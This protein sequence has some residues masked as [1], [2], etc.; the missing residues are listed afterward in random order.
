MDT[1]NNVEQ[2]LDTIMDAKTE[3]SHL[4]EKSSLQEE[5]AFN[6]V[7]KNIVMVSKNAD[8]NVNDEF[9]GNPLNMDEYKDMFLEDSGLSYLALYIFQLGFACGESIAKKEIAEFN[10]N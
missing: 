9:M 10:N 4:Y 3:Y 7:K 5:Y 8:R 2:Y 6:A 1:I